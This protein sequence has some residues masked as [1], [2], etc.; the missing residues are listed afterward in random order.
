MS[1]YERKK[2]G[3]KPFDELPEEDKES[4]R[5]FMVN[6]LKSVGET[7]SSEWLNETIQKLWWVRNKNYDGWCFTNTRTPHNIN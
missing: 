7:C 5:Q 6:S 3:Y 4:V 2:L 1:E